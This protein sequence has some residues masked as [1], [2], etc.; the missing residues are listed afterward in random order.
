MFPERKPIQVFQVTADIFCHQGSRWGNKVRS[1]PWGKTGYIPLR[2]IQLI[3]I[4]IKQQ[5]TVI[6]KYRRHGLHLHG[7]RVKQYTEVSKMPVC[8]QDNGVQNHHAAEGVLAADRTEILQQAGYRPVF[9]GNG[10]HFGKADR[11]AGEQ[12]TGRYQS[13]MM[14]SHIIR[15]CTRAQDAGKLSGQIF[16]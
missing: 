8:V 9:T 14:E 10:S 5:T 7:I 6:V 15:N 1:Q 12:G 3:R 4:Q 2:V 13:P 11:F 16:G